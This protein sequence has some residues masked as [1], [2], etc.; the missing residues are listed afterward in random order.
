MVQARESDRLDEEISA[1]PSEQISE[2]NLVGSRNGMSVRG[3]AA[4]TYHVRHPLRAMS[5]KR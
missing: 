5:S 4:T 1:F 2:E 3:R